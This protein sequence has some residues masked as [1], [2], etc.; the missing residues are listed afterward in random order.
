MDTTDITIPDARD[1]FYNFY[2]LSLKSSRGHNGELQNSRTAP[3]HYLTNLTD[4]LKTQMHK[5]HKLG[6]ADTSGHYYNSWQRL[7][8]AT[9]PAHSNTS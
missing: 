4:K 2:W 5:R 3:T 7:N 9:Q 8:Y 6:S 1:P